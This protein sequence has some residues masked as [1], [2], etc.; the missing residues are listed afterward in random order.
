MPLQPLS[1]AAVAFNRFGLGARADDTPPGDVRRWLLA[2][3]DRFEAS[4]AGLP[5]IAPARAAFVT[6]AQDREE[7][8]RVQAGLK[9]GEVIPPERKALV[10]RAFRRAADTAYRDGVAN[11]LR[12]AVETETPFV[13]RLVHFWSNH[14]TV[15][16]ERA[17]LALLAGVFEAEA[18]RPHVLGRFEDMLLAVE[19]HP[20]MLIYL[21]QVASVGPNSPHARRLA[22]KR[23]K[24]AGLNEN[25]A[26]EILELHTLG[27]RTGYAQADVTAFALALTGW[28]VGGVGP[29]TREKV[30]TTTTWFRPELHEPGA[31]TIL[32]RSY[33]AT[34]SDQSLSVLRDLARA[35]AT[36]RH[37]AT[38]LARHFAGDV[39]PPAL[40]AALA[41]AF[42]QSGGDLPTVYRALIA[43]P[44]PW[45]PQPLKFKT[46]WDWTVSS[47][48]ALGPAA[49]K[50]VRA[51]DV[52]GQLGQPVW[53]PRSPAGFDDIGQGWAGPDAVMRRVEMAPRLAA[54]LGDGIDP[55]QRAAAVLPGA[56]STM[57]AGAIARAESPTEALSLL[58]VSPEFMRR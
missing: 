23:N 38:K 25:L 26:R 8:R 45:A 53:Q 47:L 44:E 36:A 18:I 7:L 15:S 16:T 29:G 33:P 9:A 24:T 43:A 3:F 50:G 10:R 2:Q 48:R 6:Y 12:T 22:E 14:F 27:A 52:L 30:E 20:A 58:L 46:P 35:P 49:L 51:S 13:E 32:G 19:R 31:R 42:T 4:P 34:G 55:R 17:E 57:T 28:S 1:P 37:L 5:T 56:L 41:G 40:V 39:P 11:R 21:D 54:A